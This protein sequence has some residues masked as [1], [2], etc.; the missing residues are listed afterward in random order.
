MLISHVFL[1][2]FTSSACILAC[3]VILCL[4]FPFYSVGETPH[5]FSPVVSVEV[6]KL[7]FFF[8]LFICLELALSLLIGCH[9]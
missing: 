8:Y 3:H 2:F 1:A 9:G 7:F 4:C 5:N 6:T